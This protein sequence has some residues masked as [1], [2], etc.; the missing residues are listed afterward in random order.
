[1]Q[2]WE[3]EQDGFRALVVDTISSF[4]IFQRLDLK[5]RHTGDLTEAETKLLKK[6]SRVV[7]RRTPLVKYMGAETYATLS[8]KALQALGG[9]GYMQEYDSERFHRDSFGPLLYEGTSQVQALMAMKDFVKEMMKNPANFLQSIVSTNP[10][11]AFMTHTEFDRAVTNVQYEFRKNI[12][13]LILRC[14]KPELA[15]TEKGLMDTLTQINGVFKKEYW[16]EADRFDKLMVH[17]ETLCQALTYKETL[18]VLGRHASKN[19]ERGDLF[20]RYLNLLT[21]R[22]TGIYADWKRTNL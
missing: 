13:A 2:D 4:D 9:Y 11:A 8:Q 5:K 10:L 21:P 3:T 17:A 20:Y 6:A 19:K 14:F 1:L 16:Q 18:K 12:A 15:L 22:L 7:R